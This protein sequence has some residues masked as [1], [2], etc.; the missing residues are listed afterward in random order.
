VMQ[1]QDLLGL[2]Y[3]HN[4]MK[5]MSAN[6]ELRL[7]GDAKGLK[8]R[9]QA[10]DVLEAQFKAVGANPQKLAFAEVYQALQS[11]VV[12]GTENPWSNIYTQKFYEVQKDIM[13]SNHGVLDYMVI[14][15][16]G[17]WNKLPDDVRKALNTAMVESI[18]YGNKI[19]AEEAANYRQK[20]ID[21]KKAAVL[22][23]TKAELAEWRK[24]MQ[25]VWKQFEGD[26]GKDVI[27]AA[28]KS[29]KS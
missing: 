29:N 2:A 22:P 1:D 27:E 8:F 16:A 12:D 15:N 23:M 7:P 25:P 6:K 24:A 9:I 20:I 10:S 11:G 17:W 21:A 14:V 26:I 3:W 28:Q 19:A 5:E 13:E 18:K 4:G